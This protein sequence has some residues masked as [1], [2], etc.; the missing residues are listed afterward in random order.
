M[1]K[2]WSTAGFTGPYLEARLA[3]EPQPFAKA[4]NKQPFARSNVSGDTLPSC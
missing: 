3:A 4:L 2:S 1:L